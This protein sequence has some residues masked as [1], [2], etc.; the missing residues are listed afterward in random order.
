M[1]RL[2]EWRCTR[3]APVARAIASV[4]VAA[5]LALGAPGIRPA[6]AMQLTPQQKQEMKLHFERATRAYD[7]GKY[8]EAI[9]EY[10]KAY[11][12]G[13]DPPMLYNIAQAYRL[14]D[15]PSEAVRF[16]RRY[17]LRSPNARN[18][19]DVERKIS[20]LERVVEERRKAAAAAPLPPPP[21]PTAP[22]PVAAPP[23]VPSAPPVIGTGTGGESSGA[24]DPRASGRARKIV[25][26]ALIGAGAIM[27][28]VAVYEGI[29]AGQKADQVS[30][31]SMA[32][33]PVPFDPSVESAGKS[34]NTAAIV[35]GIAGGV[36]A[37]VGAVVLFTGG[38]S[39]PE[40]PRPPAAAARLTPWLGPTLVGAG[41]DVRF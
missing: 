31:M 37:A 22:P 21:P 19:D 35:L 30:S 6:T 24:G 16:Y 4:A 2:L 32:T 29:V 18:R 28:G 8:P 14:S 39:A 17:L 27:G 20:D 10:Q 23:V 3:R 9:E 15:Q 38:S 25:A 41:M 36:V 40:A 7:V 33:P 12:I 26:V 11:E 1:N 13:G 5:L 34:A